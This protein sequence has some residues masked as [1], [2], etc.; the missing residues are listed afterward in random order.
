[1]NT[2]EEI[3][4]AKKVLKSNGYYTDNLWSVEDVKSKY[5]CSDEQAYSILNS[6]LKNEATMEQIWLAIDIYSEEE[7][8]PKIKENYFL[9]NGFW[10]DDKT[11]FS[12]HL[13]YEYDDVADEDDDN[14]FYYGLSENDI[15]EA[16]KEGWRSDLDFVITSYEKVF[17]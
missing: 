15:Q 3:R 6:A 12:N 8:L 7:N 9:I 1:M 13:V 2:Q 11:K 10:K 5:L 17:E 16:I 4:K 14:I